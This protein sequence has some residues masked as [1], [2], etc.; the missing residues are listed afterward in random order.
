MGDCHEMVSVDAV[1]WAVGVPI[2]VAN[3]KI[4]AHSVQ[5]REKQLMFEQMNYGGVVSVRVDVSKVPGSSPH[6]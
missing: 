5:A 6:P 2:N 1:G 4:P 3:V